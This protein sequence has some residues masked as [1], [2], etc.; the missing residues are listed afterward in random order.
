MNLVFSIILSSLIFVGEIILIY[1][2]DFN[3]FTE[4]IITLVFV[5]I[6]LNGFIYNLTDLYIMWYEGPLYQ[7]SVIIILLNLLYKENITKIY[8]TI[9]IVSM[10]CIGFYISEYS[11][12]MKFLGTI[13]GIGVG[14]IFSCIINFSYL[15]YFQHRKIINYDYFEEMY[16]K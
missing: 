11:D 14:H 7:I 13:L 16:L 3:D 4:K 5:S 1:K 6:I 10:A 9:V 12:G 15:S 2:L 8:G